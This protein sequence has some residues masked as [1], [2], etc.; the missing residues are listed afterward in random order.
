M[1]TLPTY[2]RNVYHH[3]EIKSNAQVTPNEVKQSIHLLQKLLDHRE[4][5]L[6][7]K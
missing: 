4:D 6:K 7:G 3:P 1:L 2:I 5:I